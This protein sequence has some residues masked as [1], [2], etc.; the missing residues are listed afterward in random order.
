MES[1][2]E[3]KL[4]IERLQ[5]MELRDLEMWFR[6]GAGIGQG[7]AEPAFACADPSERR[8]ISV[9]E[10]LQ[11][12]EVSTYSNM[13]MSPVRSLQYRAQASGIT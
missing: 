5:P 10:Y 12:E 8:S 4:A 2:Q 6:A 13:S 1:I 7:V 9:E 3:I 11:L